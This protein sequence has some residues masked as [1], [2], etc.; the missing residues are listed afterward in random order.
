MAAAVILGY[1]S[2]YTTKEIVHITV[3][4]FFITLFSPDLVVWNHYHQRLPGTG[5]KMADQC[6]RKDGGWCPSFVFVSMGVSALVRL[7]GLAFICGITIPVIHA[8]GYDPLMLMIIGNAGAQAGRYTRVSP[9]ME[10]L[11]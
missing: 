5:Y 9:W 3:P 1:V 8:T 7:A 4:R 11:Y 2:D 6:I 10:I